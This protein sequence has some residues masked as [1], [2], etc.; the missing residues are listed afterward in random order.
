MANHRQGTDLTLTEIQ[1]L[2][3][4]NEIGTFVTKS[5]PV[6]LESGYEM[7]ADTIRGTLANLPTKR[8]KL[9]LVKQAFR[10]G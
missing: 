5:L 6:Y 9:A 8:Y 10:S 3:Q 2:Q 7:L 1:K 4:N